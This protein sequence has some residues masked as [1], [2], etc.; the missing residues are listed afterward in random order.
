MN[1]LKLILSNYRYLAPAML[2]A[3]L[4][5]FFGT[6]AI[7]IPSIKEKLGIDE[8]QLGFA[9]LFLGLG[10]FIMLIL[11]PTLIKK[12]GVG[13]AAALSIYLLGFSFLLPF[14]AENNNQLCLA[15][16]MVG[17]TS[18]FTD[19]AINTLVTEIE[20][21]DRLHIMSANHGFFSLGGVLS[22]GIGTFFLPQVE[23]PFNHM[24]FL[25]ILMAVINGL[26]YKYYRQVNAPEVEQASFKFSY[27]KPLLALVVI[28]FFVMASEGAIADWSALYL[29][30]VSMA[31]DNL[32][33]LGY[34]AFS[35]TMALGRF[36]GDGVSLRYGSRNIILTGSL[37]AALGF[38]LILMVKTTL[39]IIGFGF[40]G[41]GFSV[42]VPELF[43]LGGKVKN[44]DAAQAV[45]IV[46]G[47]G[48]L[49][50]LVGPVLLGFLAKSSSLK[51]SFVA[52]LAFT[53]VAFLTAYGLKK[54]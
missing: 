5:I 51:L 36:L 3:T 44:V 54:R 13:K 24:L 34:T 37:L 18:G 47:S 33:G 52:L 17:F 15:L 30:K 29:E 12:I 39:A 6:W 8:G 16:L 1:S 42:I 9:I 26:L 53:S 25:V 31:K 20:K 7:Y 41:L 45:S 14:L 38:T 19:I 43:R 49:G 35:A 48:F 10:T 21:E 40:V 46:A 4:N 28:G 11:S 50:F 32:I 2:F 22:A 27:L 23:N